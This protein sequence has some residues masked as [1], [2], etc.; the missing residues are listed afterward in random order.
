MQC[1]SRKLILNQLLI[2][3]KPQLSCKG[4]TDLSVAVN[5]RQTAPPNPSD[6]SD[7]SDLFRTSTYI[8]AKAKNLKFEQ[9]LNFVL[10]E[11]HHES[12]ITLM[13][14]RQKLLVCQGFEVN[15][16]KVLHFLLLFF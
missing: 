11:F 15:F 13:R 2:H 5:L 4:Q 9:D 7:P 6:P 14:K 8:H 3:V 1:F 10:T 12:L 16:I